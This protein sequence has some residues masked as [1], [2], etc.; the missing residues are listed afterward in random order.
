MT[1]T[2]TGAARRALL[3]ILVTVLAVTAPLLATGT[4]RAASGSVDGREAAVLERIN[5]VRASY[6]LA[7]FARHRKLSRAAD[8]HSARM[9]RARVVAHQVWGEGGLG[10][11]LRWAIGG[12]KAGEVLYWGRGG[13]R[14]ATIV[15]A[16]MNSPGHRAILLSG[17]FTRVG[18]GLRPGSGGLYATVDVA[19]R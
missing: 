12:A 3:R 10:A 2:P 16:W 6:G 5:D 9:A 11:R 8:H 1:S 4:A 14:S 13:V 17:E 7:P 19:A 15:R 18:I